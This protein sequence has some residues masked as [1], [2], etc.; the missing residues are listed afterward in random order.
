MPGVRVSL[1]DQA[2]AVAREVT[3]DMDGV[4]N[5]PDLPPAVYEI[6]LSAPGFVTQMWTGIVVG[7]GTDRVL[8]IV[9]RPGDPK[10]V[11]RTAAPPAS[12][13]QASACCGGN[14]NSSTGRETPLNRSGLAEL[15]TLQ[16]GGP[17]RPKGRAP[18]RG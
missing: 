3:T 15:G 1:S 9:M 8:N 13:S 12:I 5:L 10:T 4:Y 16:G 17:R 7:V 11:V 14:V 6:T 18:R 2:S